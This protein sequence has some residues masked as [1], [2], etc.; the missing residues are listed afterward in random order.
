MP[1]FDYDLFISH[2]SEDKEGFVRELVDLLV[3]RG[4]RVWFDE[5][6]LQV[7]D[8]LVRSIDDGLSRSRFGVVILSR[9]FFAKQWPRAELDALA[10]RELSG[11]GRVVVLPIWLDV[12]RDEVA[13]YSPLLATKLALLS[14]EGVQGIADKLERRVRGGEPVAGVALPAR[15]E[16]LL[17][18]GR[19]LPYIY[20]PYIRS[21]DHALS[22]RVAIAARMPTDPE[23]TLRP[24]SQQLFE[25]AL[26]GSQVESFMQALTMHGRRP[27]AEHFWELVDPT[28]TWV[29]TAARPSAPMSGIDGFAAEAR[30]AVA[31]KHQPSLVPLGWL[32]MHVDIAIR[33]MYELRPDVIEPIPLSLD[34][35]FAL[36]HVPLRAILDEIAPVVLP[37]ITGAE[38]DLLA[39]GCVVMPHGD[40]FSRYVAFQHYAERRISGSSDPSAIDWY[41]SS[42]DEVAEPEARTAAVRDRIEGLFIDGG[43]RGFEQHLERLS[44]ARLGPPAAT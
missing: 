43:Y 25:D 44:S 34:D 17:L 29:I 22:S 33:P 15:L 11:D 4:L 27:R 36:V 8:S 26:A 6:E 19:I 40:P 12:G 13:V 31:L 9:A 1:E 10:N 41:P 21:E 42:L 38:G 30:A 16:P 2:A 24:T 37:A 3:A 28:R 5:A 18:R 20:S 7:G 32:I 23:P 39:V 14:G 35:L